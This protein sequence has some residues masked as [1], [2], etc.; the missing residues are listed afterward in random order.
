MKKCNLI[1]RFFDI[2]FSALA[3]IFFSPLFLLI[4]FILNFT[5][6]SKIFFFQRRVG[7]NKKIFKLIKFATMLENSPSIGTK[8]ITLQ[9]DP[10]V[11]P[12]G[13]FL[14]KYKINELP[15]LWNVINGDM[16]LV[17]PRPLTED[18]FDLYDTNVKKKILKI[19]PGL[20][21]I[22]SIIFRNEQKLFKNKNK[23]NL[24]KKLVMPYKAKLEIWFLKNHSLYTYF[25]CIF[26]TLLSIF[27]N[28]SNFL[29]RLLK[30]LPEP[31]SK[32]KK[33]LK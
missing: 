5:G 1:I 3:I 23:I 32:L 30:S 10:R 18:H 14:R 2:S 21:G 17:G 9:D 19:K 12:V 24:Y 6:E 11:L 22:S 28:R 31:Q 33:L 7:L 25:V 4:V 16:S 27:L 29:Y 13:V 26:S 20:T 8:N 15:Q